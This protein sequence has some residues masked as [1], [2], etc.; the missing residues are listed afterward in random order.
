MAKTAT[1]T[2]VPKHLKGSRDLFTHVTE[3]YS[4]DLHHTKLLVGACE[5]LDRATEARE[6]LLRDG[7]TILDRYGVTKCHPMVRVE[8]GSKSQF[9]S[10]VRALG[11]DLA[12]S[13]NVPLNALTGRRGR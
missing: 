11:L 2:T 8:Q 7:L 5:S 12:E 1:K 9:A 10:L 4:L 13:T 3:N 6:I